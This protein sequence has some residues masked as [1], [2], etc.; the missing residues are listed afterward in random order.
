M[1]SPSRGFRFTGNLFANY[2][3]KPISYT[4]FTK[5]RKKDNESAKTG[6]S[7]KKPERPHT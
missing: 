5:N 7:K 6:K 1:I 3:K 2:R 4:I